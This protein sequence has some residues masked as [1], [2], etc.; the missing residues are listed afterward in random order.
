MRCLSCWEIHPLHFGT[1]PS[2]CS[3]SFLL[4]IQLS[5]PRGWR[6]TQQPGFFLRL[7]KVVDRF[8]KSWS[9]SWPCCGVVLCF[10]RSLLIILLECQ[11]GWVCFKEGFWFRRLARAWNDMRISRHNSKFRQDFSKHLLCSKHAAGIFWG[12]WSSGLTL[13]TLKAMAEK[14]RW[15]SW[16]SLWKWLSFATAIGKFG[17]FHQNCVSSCAVQHLPQVRWSLGR[18][19]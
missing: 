2:Q 18:Q 10:L 1:K 5:M 12:I 7:G 3:E 8:E 19:G 15:A 6:G 9:H 14:E 13:K 11:R 17:F 4:S 16:G